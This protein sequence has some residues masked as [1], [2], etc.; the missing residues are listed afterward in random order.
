MLLPRKC[1]NSMIINDFNIIIVVIDHP[2]AY[3]ILVIDT[4][5][6]LFPS[7]SGESLQSI[8]RRN[9][10]ILQTSCIVYHDQLSKCDSLNCYRQFLRKMLVVY[11]L[12][13]FV[14]KPLYHGLIIH[15][16]CVHVKRALH[17]FA[18]NADY[19]TLRSTAS[20]LPQDSCP[21]H[22]PR[23]KLRSHSKSPR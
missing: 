3:P 15:V 1:A 5:A 11:F 9:H 12:C 16:S 14:C 22:A 4:N 18:I 17:Q 19:P 23:R 2:K 20:A 7:V 6:I 8:R 13:F 21:A 10:Q